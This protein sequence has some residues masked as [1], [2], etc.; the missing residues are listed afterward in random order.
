VLFVTGVPAQWSPQTQFRGQGRG[1]TGG[2]GEIQ[3]RVI[4]HGGDNKDLQVLL[5]DQ[6]GNQTGVADVSLIGT[7]SFSGV[8]RGR[9][10]LRLLD[11]GRPVSE[12]FVTVEDLVET[13]DLTRPRDRRENIG[14]GTVSVSELRHKP[15][16]LALKETQKGESALRKGKVEEAIGHFEGALAADPDFATVRE[17]LAN[18][19]L[20][21]HD[22]TRAIPHLE[23]L[24][25]QRASS[26]WAW[27]NLGAARL[28]LGRMAEA[29]VAAR[30][31]LALDATQKISRYILG[32][33]L[34]S[35]NKNPDEALA[36]LRQTCDK[37]PPGHL[38][39]A[40]ILESR[41]DIAGAR[42]EL[43]SYLGSDLPE[44]A[45]EAKDWLAQH[46]R[47]QISASATAP[48]A[49]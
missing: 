29:E 20:Q 1:E 48:A 10:T 9:Y 39:A 28:R 14:G 13:V 34:A 23:A 3:G 27:I 33:S 44:G 46:P 12:G 37:F 40:R 5:I 22:D 6:S 31:A 7:F 21:N 42:D 11:A 4:P 16:A 36:S 26:V 49:R 38:A 24:L 25:K 43:E 8:Q 2:L 15:P 18:L 41:G 35:Q 30:R 45:A 17:G 47:P 19:Y 32:I